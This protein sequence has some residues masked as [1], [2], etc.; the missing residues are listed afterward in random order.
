MRPMALK[1]LVASKATLKE[2]D[3]EAIVADYVRYDEDEKE[4]A[5]TP[6]GSALAA[7][8]KLLIYLVAL[9]GWPFISAD[10]PTDASPTEISEHLGMPGGTVRPM[11]GELRDR[12]LIAAK[13]GRYF[14]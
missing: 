10:V 8:K 5:F 1:D 6:G 3:I 13:A 11:L 9:Q 4:I 14:V 7:R 12:N 2:A